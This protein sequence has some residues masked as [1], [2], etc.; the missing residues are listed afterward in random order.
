MGSKSTKKFIKLSDGGGLLAEESALMTS[1]GPGDADRLP[2]LGSDGRLHSS[3]LPTTWPADRNFESTQP[4]PSAVWNIYHGL[5]KK[6]SFMVF[7]SAGD[8]VE[9]QPEFISNDEIRIT[10]SAAFSG[11]AVLN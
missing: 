6:P 2:A 11:F 7:D 4:T 1:D 3:M 8:E 10:F 5:G 9:G